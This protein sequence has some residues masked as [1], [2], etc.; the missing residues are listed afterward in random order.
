MRA[1]VT[2]VGAVGFTKDVAINAEAN[3]SV[4]GIDSTGEVGFTLVWGNISPDQSSNFNDI[5]PAQTPSWGQI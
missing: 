5:I 3:V 1:D 2:G 4:L